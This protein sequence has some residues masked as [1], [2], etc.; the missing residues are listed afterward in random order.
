VWGDWAVRPAD[1]Q[2]GNGGGLASEGL[3]SL[4]EVENPARPAVP[5]EVRDPIRILS[6]HNPHWGTPWIHSELLKLGIE[7]TEPTVAKYI[8]RQRKSPRQTWRTFLQNYITGLVSVDFFTVP[9]IRFQS[10]YVFLV[11]AHDWRR[12]PPSV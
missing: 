6:R 3:S 9:T 12:I 7:I 10:L 1:C 2:A 11:L 5:Q 4:L 8:V